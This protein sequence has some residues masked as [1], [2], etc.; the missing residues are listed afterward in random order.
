MSK[1]SKKNKRNQKETFV[2]SGRSDLKFSQDQETGEV[3]SGELVVSKSG[4]E[5]EKIELA[6]EDCLYLLHCIMHICRD[7]SLPTE[8][9][10]E[11]ARESISQRIEQT[12][13]ITTCIIDAHNKIIEKGYI[14]EI[15][16]AEI[17]HIAAAGSAILKREHKVSDRAAEGLV[18]VFYH[19]VVGAGSD[20]YEEMLLSIVV[21]LLRAS[22]D[23]YSD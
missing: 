18:P 19:P 6:P 23:L 2:P 7:S 21:T 22:S 10:M 20:R 9:C 3:L 12:N 14:S 11:A 13:E 5:I 4:Q 17:I 15:S 8:V 1:S 16:R